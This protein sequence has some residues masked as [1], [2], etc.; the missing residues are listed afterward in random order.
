MQ[1]FTFGYLFM[2][3]YLSVYVIE[4][5]VSASQFFHFSLRFIVFICTGAAFPLGF[6]AVDGILKISHLV[7]KV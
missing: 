2:C 3:V 6:F 5:I 1:V 4:Y 7:I